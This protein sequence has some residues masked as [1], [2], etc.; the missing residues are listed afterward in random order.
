MTSV[1]PGANSYAVVS[2][3]TVPF[4]FT[5]MPLASPAV[6]HRQAVHRQGAAINVIRARQQ[7][8]AERAR[9]LVASANDRR[10]N[11]RCIIRARD[12]DRP[13]SAQ[14]CRPDHQARCSCTQ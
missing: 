11:R 5:V 8:H 12:R 13:P 3:V 4:A 6:G 14:R 2:T 10:T 9:V 1:A 7:V